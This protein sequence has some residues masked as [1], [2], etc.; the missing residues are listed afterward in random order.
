MLTIGSGHN[1]QCSVFFLNFF[2][3]YCIAETKTYNKKFLGKIL[4]P[5][6]RLKCI[7]TIDFWQNCECG[8]VERKVF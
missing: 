8:S 7:W 3:I 6:S 4:E 1:V 2:Q 5:K